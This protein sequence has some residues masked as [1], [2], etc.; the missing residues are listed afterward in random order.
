MGKVCC[1]CKKILPL[2]NFKS[3]SRKNG[4]QGQCILCQKKYRRQHYLKNRQKYIDKARKL[5]HEFALWWKNYK[6][7]F[8]C[9]RCGEK[10]PACI[11]FHHPNDDKD[12]NVS[13][14]AVNSSKKRLLEEIAKCIP[15]CANCHF[16]EHWHEP[17][18]G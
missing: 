14:L 2:E 1:M 10:H 9:V 12:E 4:L 15:L 7:Q 17:I 5:N 13:R 18:E 6:S 11:Q 8:S 16:K 3:S